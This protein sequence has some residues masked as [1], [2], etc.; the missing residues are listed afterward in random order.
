VNRSPL[1][2]VALLFA[3][4]LPFW[5]VGALAPLQPLPALPISALQA[6]PAQAPL[7]R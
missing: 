7:P 6:A 3:L 2:F 4:S 1:A 5:V